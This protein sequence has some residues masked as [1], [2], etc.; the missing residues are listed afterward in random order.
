MR[1]FYLVACFLWGLASVIQAQTQTIFATQPAISPDGNQVAFSF[2]GDI[3]VMAANGGVARRLTIH[4]GYDANPIWSPDGKHIAFSSNRASNYDVFTIP[5]NGGATKRLTYHSSGDQATCWT[6]QNEVLFTSRVRAYRQIAYEREIHKVSAEGGT[7]QR[8][9]DAQGYMPTQSPNGKLIAFVRGTCGTVREAYRGPANRNVWIYNNE[10]KQYTQL[11]ND[12]SNE[13]QPAW[14]DD[15]TLYYISAKSGKYN[16]Y[17]QKLKADGTA[18]GNARQITRYTNDGI[19]YFGVS[20]NNQLIF[21]R[22]INLYTMNANERKAKKLTI[23]ATHDY[24]FDQ[25]TH[26]TYRNGV[27]DYKVAPNGKYVAVEIR[28][29]I[30]IKPTA[31]DKRKAVNLSAHAFRDE[32]PEWLNDSTLVFISDRNGQRDLYLVRSIDKKQNNLY[33]TLKTKVIQLTQTKTEEFAPT[34]SPNGKKIAYRR[35]RGELVVAS[36][37]A[38][39]KLSNEKVLVKGWATPGGIAWSPDSRWLSYSLTDLNFNQE[40]YIQAADNSQPGVN[41]SMHPRGDYGAV[42]S[43]DGSKLAFMSNRIND[44]DVWFVWLNRADWEKSKSDHEEGGYYDDPD[45]KKSKPKKNAP[46]NIDFE[47]IHHRVARVTALPG[48]EGGLAI[49]NKGHTFYFTATNPI[50]RNH[51][52]DLYQV[53]WDG[54]QTKMLTQ[55]GKNPYGLLLSPKGKKLHFLA[56][57]VLQ[58]TLLK[59]KKTTALPHEAKM[60]IDHHQERIQMFEEGWRALQAGFYDPD[61]HGQNFVAL[62]KKYKPW[63]L[64]ASTTQDFR[65]IFNRMLGQLN[66]SHMGLYGSN[67]ETIQ[68]ERTGLL[69]AEVVPVTTGV[70]IA[71]V[72]RHAPADK[73]RSKLNEGEI[74]TKVNGQEVNDKVN[75]YSLLTNTQNERVMLTVQGKNGIREVIIRPIKS[76]SSLLYEEWVNNQKALVKKYS[77]GRLGYIHIRGMNMPSF[78]RFERELM[79]SGYGKE[80]IVIDVRF[81]GGGWTTDYLMAVLNVRQHAYTI[82]RGAVKSLQKEHKKYRNYYPFSERLPLS[83]WVKPSVALCNENSYSNAEIFSHAY[84]HLGIGKLVGTPTFGA[85]ISTGSHR[86]IDGSRVRMPFRAWYVK[87]TEKNME[88]GPAV[89]DFVLDNVPD[90]RAKKEDAQL[91]KA[92]EVLLKQIDTKK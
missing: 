21:E 76:L 85:V 20:R 78:E 55:R 29:E 83:S 62:R 52:Y 47:N 13:F 80:G 25:V 48:D 89:P 71:H 92:V 86:L 82:P 35:G 22:Q 39:G 53:K 16:I 58:Q 1:K 66:A 74:I 88:L 61:F 79:A 63:A 67:P 60:M 42:W 68:R 33:K 32:S 46:V 36:I 57:G 5:A 51:Q 90:N 10:T 77:G 31:K 72:I 18:N 54:S 45:K 26:Q 84:K 8:M 9:L 70:K 75:F 65:M 43:P 6:A 30:F 69:G 50:A 34:L 44:Y 38:T 11:T 64:A 49:G 87:A 73:I 23:Q 27:A 28:G 12:P 56:N 24:R 3:W 2:Q 4:R 37:S 81:N 40:I 41:I 59:T 19:R 17:Q 7:P 15:N 14:S 91:K